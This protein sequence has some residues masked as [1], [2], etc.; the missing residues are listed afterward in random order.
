MDTMK[1]LKRTHYCTQLTTAD[2]GKEVVA[3][4]F[5]QKVRNLG[6][7]VF[8]DLRDRTG[9]L[10]LA[11]DDTVDK[12]LLQKASGVHAEYVLM[13]AGTVRKRESVNPDIPTGEIEVL[14]N[15]LRILSAAKTPPFEVTDQT[16]V[17]D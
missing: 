7:L 16:N 17:K 6:N 10:Q 9:I 5:V 13:A 4:G 14:V 15:D 12:Q 2:I 11:F 1:G 3:A 8:I